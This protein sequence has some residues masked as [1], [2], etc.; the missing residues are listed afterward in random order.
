[1]DRR[2]NPETTNSQS[3]EQFQKAYQVISLSYRGDEPERLYR[4][5]I[6]CFDTLIEI[7]QGNETIREFAHRHSID[8]KYL[9]DGASFVISKMHFNHE[10]NFYVT[11]GLPQHATPEELSRR[12]KKFMLLYHPDKQVGNEEWVSERAKKVNEAYT[13]L[14]DEAKR[15]EY[16]RRLNE[17]MLSRKFSP[18]NAHGIFP[19]L[20]PSR[21]AGRRRRH[22][23]SSAAWNSIRPYMPKILFALYALT[24]LIVFG[25]IYNQ[26]KSSHLE[27]ELAPE[28]ARAGSGEGKSKAAVQEHAQEHSPAA[29]VERSN[30]PV[31][32]AQE[33]KNRSAAASPLQTIRHW[34]KPNGPKQAE[35]K[36][37]T[38]T[39]ADRQTAAA[40]KEDRPQDNTT[41][42]QLPLRPANAEQPQRETPQ[43]LHADIQKAPAESAEPVRPLQEARR[44]TAAEPKTE[45]IT[46]EEV[47]EFMQRYIGVYT[48]NDLNAFLALFSR[49]AVENNTL[50]YNEMRSAYK[51][52]FSE[53]INNYK[54]SNM[55]IR[56]DGQTTTVSG[57]YTINRYI[58]AEDRWARY[59][60]KIVWKLIR[61]NSQLRI[62]SIN[63]DK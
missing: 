29:P 59:S 53:K 40:K 3:D 5:A 19:H 17:Q 15:A 26:N 18:A 20:Q 23:G 39:R 56:T 42:Q 54:I 48:K 27:A 24:A 46:K 63:Y 14:K 60:G 41:P 49:S 30:D 34:F 55:D 12:W 21:T 61:E 47:E 44:Q 28:A 36:V 4:E 16:D 2:D 25:F 50:T 38:D 58:S 35:E 13:A 32:P 31:P 10:N 62:I 8:M 6:N 51:A 22:E 9:V 7:S 52:T 45:Q 43:Q 37:R 1:M 33:T 57:T 11:L